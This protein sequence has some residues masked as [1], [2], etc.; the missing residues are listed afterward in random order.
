MRIILFINSMNNINNNNFKTKLLFGNL[1]N[2]ERKLYDE[3]SRL[4]DIPDVM[5]ILGSSE[6][7]V[8][9]YLQQEFKQSSRFKIDKIHP[10]GV[11]L[12]ESH[13][14]RLK[15]KSSVRFSSSNKPNEELELQLSN[16][17]EQKPKLRYFTMGSRQHPKQFERWSPEEMYNWWLELR[18]SGIPKL[19]WKILDAVFFLF[20]NQISCICN[21]YIRYGI[22]NNSNTKNVFKEE[23]RLLS[24][25]F[26]LLDEFYNHSGKYGQ[27][28]DTHIAFC[29]WFQFRIR[30]GKNLN[31]YVENQN[32]SENIF[33]LFNREN[34][35]KIIHRLL[36]YEKY[37]NKNAEIDKLR[38][39]VYTENNFYLILFTSYFQN[40]SKFI[41]LYSIPVITAVGVPHKSHNASFYSPF[42]QILHDI[43][44]HSSKLQKYLMFLYNQKNPN[45]INI[46]RKKMIFLQLLFNKKAYNAQLLFWF[47]IHEIYSIDWYLNISI[48]PEQQNK[49]KRKNI[50]LLSNN[51]RVKARQN[52]K[53]EREEYLKK[54]KSGILSKHTTNVNKKLQYLKMNDENIYKF[55]DIEILL[56]QLKLMKIFLIELTPEEKKEDLPKILSNIDILIETCEETIEILK[57]ERNKNYNNYMRNQRNPHNI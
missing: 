55:F 21:S 51:E 26:R 38:E 28:L 10:S 7:F 14:K 13:E 27:L 40:P 29:N 56:E 3:I 36:K 33:K 17:E 42:S 20:I 1:S 52:I 18:T 41:S 8:K 19:E 25:Y 39:I 48:I 34:G 2:S 54:I 11:P 9:E 32:Q 23:L 6:F 44:I 22:K 16:F 30:F 31:S 37:S 15:G 45:D 12:K 53:K 43:F 47:I 5:R 50:L 24:E 46:F 35:N 49:K 57:N 4:V